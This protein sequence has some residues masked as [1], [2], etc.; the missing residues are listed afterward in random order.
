MENIYFE[1]KKKIIKEIYKMCIVIYILIVLSF[2]KK[3]LIFK[4]FGKYIY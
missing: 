3:S 4:I 2:V 1:L